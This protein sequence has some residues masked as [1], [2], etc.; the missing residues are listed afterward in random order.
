M[1]TLKIEIATLKTF[2]KCAYRESSKFVPYK[3]L[4]YVQN[5]YYL[6]K[7]RDITLKILKNINAN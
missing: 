4:R 2:V 6:A 1:V 3:Q 5:I 7:Q